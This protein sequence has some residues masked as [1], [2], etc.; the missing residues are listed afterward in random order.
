MV[1]ITDSQGNPV[2]IA[3]SLTVNNVVEGGGSGGT[4]TIDPSVLNMFLPVTAGSSKPLTGVLY[5]NEGIYLG[6]DATANNAKGITFLNTNSQTARLGFSNSGSFGLYTSG[7]T[8]LQTSA[9][10][11][12]TT[13]T[14]SFGNSTYQY[15]NIYGKAIYQNGKQV[16][17]KEEV[18]TLTTAVNN[19][20]AVIISEW[21][22]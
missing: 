10:M 3:G 5:A 1:I 11:P 19:K 22:K 8:Y 4:A 7:E 17:N 14:T 12:I 18:T 15:N 9:I 16:A 20:S 21:S 2:E 13:N 6:S